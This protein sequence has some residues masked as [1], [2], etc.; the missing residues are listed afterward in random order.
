MKNDYPSD[1]AVLTPAGVVSVSFQG[2][3]LLC[4]RFGPKH[5]GNNGT[6]PLTANRIPMRGNVYLRDYGKGFELD[7]G[8]YTHRPGN[9]YSAMNVYRCD[10]G[11]CDEPPIGAKNK[12]CSILE[13]ALVTWSREHPELVAEASKVDHAREVAAAR[14]KVAECA[15]AL[16]EAREELSELEDKG[17]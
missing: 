4:A 6:E 15:A 13:A 1:I 2:A 16:R 14:E 12:L 9:S 5:D 3:N 7:R 11:F 8:Q 10:K 17:L